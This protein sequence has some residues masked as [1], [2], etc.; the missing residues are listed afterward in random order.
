VYTG[1]CAVEWSTALEL[2]S[3][4]LRFE[5]RALQK[6]CEHFLESSECEVGALCGFFAEARA[7]FSAQ[8][9][10]AAKG[11]GDSLLARLAARLAQHAADAMR[12]GFVELLRDQESLLVVLHHPDL[13]VRNEAELF[14]AIAHWLRMYSAPERARFSAANELLRCINFA[15]MDPADL[16]TVV[17][18]SGLL[19]RAELLAVLKVRAS[20]LRGDAQGEVAAKALC[21]RLDLDIRLPQPQQPPPQPLPPPPPAP[22]SVQPPA[23]PTLRAGASEPRFARIASLLNERLGARRS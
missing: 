20:R 6:R 11:F 23:P 9:H 12:P 19:E 2:L 15:K 22:A 16:L 10:A 21:R 17:R 3:A 4:A 14:A 5:V 13:S 7:F 18:E 8:E 1:Q